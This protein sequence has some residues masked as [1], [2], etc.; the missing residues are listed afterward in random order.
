MR[1]RVVTD[2]LLDEYRMWLYASEKSLGTIKKYFRY[3]RLFQEFMKGEE[4]NKDRV[5]VWKEEM[6]KAF[7]CQYGECGSGGGERHFLNIVSGQNVQRKFI[8]IN[9]KI[10]WQEQQLLSVEEYKR[11]VKTA[12]ELGQEKLAL[13]LQTVC[14]TGIRISELQYITVEAADKGISEV[15]CKGRVRTIFLTRQICWRLKYY[16]DKHGIQTGMIF[17]TRNGKP[18]DRSNIWRKMQWLGIWAGVEAEKIYPHNLRHLFAR[19][20]Y[21]QERDLSRLADILGHS[22]INTTRIY[23]IESGH[24]HVMQM[25]KLNL[26]I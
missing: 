11:M 14:S 9:R 4:V 26:T 21:D 6:K 7:L 3:L 15:D 2:E 24:S 12:Q 18:L 19:S 16:A 1:D 10:F 23:T 25:E 5:I 8:R 17:V 20:Y 13:L 22:S